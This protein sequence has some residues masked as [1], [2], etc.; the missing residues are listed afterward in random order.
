MQY[1][2][3]DIQWSLRTWPALREERGQ[4]APMLFQ[5]CPSNLWTVSLS[6]I[7]LLQC[8]PGSSRHSWVERALGKGSKNC[9]PAT[10]PQAT[11]PTSLTSGFLSSEV[12]LFNKAHFL[13]CV[14]ELNEIMAHV[15]SVEMANK[16]FLT[17]VYCEKQM[18][19]A[20]V[21]CWEAQLKEN[22]MKCFNNVHMSS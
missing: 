1:R 9:L 2:S 18:R 20:L 11:Q 5:D 7:F 14:W 12:G 13:G 19:Q 10:W 21:K 22:K 16:C 8:V 6:F 15:W 4:E 17:F 3:I